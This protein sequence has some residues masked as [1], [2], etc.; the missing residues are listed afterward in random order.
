MAMALPAG[1]P[2]APLASIEAGEITGARTVTFS[3]SEPENPPAANYQEFAFL[4]D[5]RRFDLNRV[6]QR[7]RLGAVEEWTVVNDH[8]NDHVFHIHTNPFQVT[9]LNGAPLTAPV[10]RDTVIVP[11]NG[12]LTFR[13]RFLDFTGK[14]VLH[15]HMMNHEELGMM[16]LIEISDSA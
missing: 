1:L 9:A 16:Q 4:I 14:T 5:G 11:R 13:S 8:D 15:C 2:A 7:I 10:W 3:A 6:D 12:S